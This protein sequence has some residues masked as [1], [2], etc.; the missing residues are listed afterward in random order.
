MACSDPTPP[1]ID[2]Q[3]DAD[4]DDG[5]PT[6][7]ELEQAIHDLLDEVERP[8][9]ALTGFTLKPGARADRAIVALY[10]AV[11]RQP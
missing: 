8:V 4:D 6:T 3:P 11:G 1:E 5:K 10:D 2:V 7:A 9:G